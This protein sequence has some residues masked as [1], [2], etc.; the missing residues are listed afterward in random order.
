[1][2]EGGKI[3]PQNVVRASYGRRRF[4][5]CLREGGTRWGSPTRRQVHYPQTL[6]DDHLAETRLALQWRLL[7]LTEKAQSKLYPHAARWLA[8][9]K[10]AYIQSGRAA[11]WQV[12]FTQLKS[13]YA[14]RPALQKELA[15][16]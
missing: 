5:E 7:A 4:L 10:K 3:L 9:V 12:Y 11:E 6:E 14:R 8:K 16:L 2:P 15:K 1:M 13:T